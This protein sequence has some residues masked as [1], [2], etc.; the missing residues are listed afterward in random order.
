[1]G[2]TARAK[3][4]EVRQMRNRGKLCKEAGDAIH[5]ALLYYSRTA[6]QRDQEPVAMSGVWDKVSDKIIDA[7]QIET[8][9]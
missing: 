4:D 6:D 1:M 8:G 7:L 3:S 9:E 2:L 5:H